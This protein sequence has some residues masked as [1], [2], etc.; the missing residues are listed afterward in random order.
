MG[1]VVLLPFNTNLLHYYCITKHSLL[2][3]F[4]PRIYV[5]MNSIAIL[6]EE[7]RQILEKIVPE[8]HHELLRQDHLTLNVD[9]EKKFGDLSSHV[10]LMLSKKTKTAPLVLAQTLQEK[11]LSK[12]NAVLAGVIKE[13]T[14]A[15][16]GFVNITL[17]E[18][19]WALVATQLLKKKRTYFLLPP[20]DRKKYLVE[21]V[22]VNPTGP[23][24]HGHARGAIVGDTL[25][26]VATF[27]GHQVTKEYYINDAGNQITLLGKS[28][29]IRCRQALGY[30]EPFLENGYAGEYIIELAQQCSVEFGQELLHK[31]DAFFAR[32]AKDHMLQL[33]KHDLVSYGVSFDNWF[34]ER[35]LHES[36]AVDEALLL[37]SSKGFAYEQDGALWFKATAFGDDKDRVLRKQDG[38]V[39][40]IAP[41]IA[42]HKN[43]FE[44]GYD[45]LINVFGQD[46]HGYVKRLKATLS[47][48][49]YDAERLHV[50]LVQLVTFKESDLVL[51]MSK[52]S[53]KFISLEEVINL[54]GTDVARFFYLNRKPDAHLEFD[55]QT[56]L[57]TTDENPVFYIQYAYVRTNS[58]LKKAKEQAEYDQLF[59]LLQTTLH[60]QELFALLEHTLSNGEIILIKKIISLYDAARAVVN[61]FQTHTLAYYSWELAHD[62]HTYYAQ[63]R[64]IDPQDYKTT[65]TRLALVALVHQTLDTCLTLLGLSKPDSM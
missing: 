46:H 21:F 61:Q 62:F 27:L 7:I 2:S 45:F 25:A 44:R 8:E 1:V 41:D 28:L 53:G 24:H 18:T 10:A 63:H 14:V 29:A 50:I 22:S 55:L 26:R 34:S 57:K 3:I 31:D 39:T 38:E 43:K 13:V 5:F 51:K 30:D 65:A 56:A 20:A 16:P 48:L 4:L 47:A 40:Y 9:A 49:G 37:L 17:Q 42:Y 35:S 52:R 64:I 11:L 60:E 19:A 32:Y 59:D 6:K 23:M 58:I 33:I 15:P 36:G 54:V 12:E